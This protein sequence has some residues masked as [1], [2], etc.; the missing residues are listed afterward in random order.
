MEARR[1]PITKIGEFDIG[2][3]GRGVIVHHWEFGSNWLPQG[4]DVPVLNDSIG[5][6]TAIELHAI[7]HGLPC[8][9]AVQRAIDAAVNGS[10]S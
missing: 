9:C 8:D 4:S 3:N 1:L 7:A 5:G 6:W 10:S 2:P